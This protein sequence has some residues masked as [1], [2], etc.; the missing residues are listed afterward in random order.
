MAE[1]KACLK[2]TMI[3]PKCRSSA[4]EQITENYTIMICKW[5]FFCIKF[6]SCLKTKAI[7]QKL[8]QH[9]LVLVPEYVSVL[10]SF[11]EGKSLGKTQPCIPE[12]TRHQHRHNKMQQSKVWYQWW[13]CYSKHWVSFP[14]IPKRGRGSW[15]RGVE[16]VFFSFPL[17]VS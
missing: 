8:F 15:A 7:L 16:R 9:T 1:T 13:S 6:V 10:S 14:A 4:T 17:C 5:A 11:I 12:Q 3:L 2:I